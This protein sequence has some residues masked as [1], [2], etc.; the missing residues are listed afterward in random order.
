MRLDYFGTLEEISRLMSD[1]VR[2]AC[3]EHHSVKV[4]E[5]VDIRKRIDKKVYL[6]ES[7]LLSEF[8]PPLQ[9]SDIVSYSHALSRVAARA[10]QCY[11]EGR[12]VFLSSVS[13]IKNEEARICVALSEQLM[14]DTKLLRALRRS[15]KIPAVEDFREL[16]AKGREAHRKALLKVNSGVLS[17]S[18][19]Y[20]VS[21]L[22]TLRQ[23]LGECY[24]RLIELI[25]DNI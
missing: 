5:S 19:L 24:E 21:S 25:L 3:E 17:R 11:D 9:R 14:S 7:S 16:F 2:L 8:I 10:E 4:G 6:I 18:C 20:F 12:A 23:E 1:A 15:A 13:G 22:G